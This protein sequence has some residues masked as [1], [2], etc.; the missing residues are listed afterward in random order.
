MTIRI[1][2]DAMG[3]D[4]GPNVIIEGA[5]AGARGQKAKALLV[6]NVA[7]MNA[8][9]SHIDT[10][11]ADYEVVEATDVITMDDHPAQAVRRKPQSSINVALRLLAEGKA[12]AMV[13]AGNSG[14][15]MA[16]AL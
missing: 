3:G 14:A 16:G 4:H 13:S 6:G 1:A 7:V 8:A 12:D 2:V 11:S 10:T 9:L 15:V 5:I